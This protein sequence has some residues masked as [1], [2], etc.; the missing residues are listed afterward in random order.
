MLAWIAGLAVVALLAIPALLA[1]VGGQPSGGGEVGGPPAPVEFPHLILN[2][3]DTELVDAY[4]NFDETGERVG[5]HTVYQQTWAIA[6]SDVVDRVGRREILLRIQEEGAVF[7]EFD[8]YSA[9]AMGTETVEVNGRSVTVYL[10]PGEA[11]EEG[12][13]DLGI[14]QWTE[15]PGY[16]V[17]LIPWGLDKDGALSLMDGLTSITES[18]WEELRGPKDGPFVT[19]TIVESETPTTG[20]AENPDNGAAGRAPLPNL[21]GLDFNQAVDVIK[22]FE[23]LTGVRISL[24]SHEQVVNDP[25]LVARVIATDPAPGTV[26]TRT[27]S[28]TV[29]VGK[30]P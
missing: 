28:V 26:I 10:V 4:E 7:D 18:E 8:Y 11:V 27:G 6:D 14:L 30:A 25:N 24:L 20:P 17:I 16:E 9:L 22:E 13:Y 3:P 2:L 23:Q 15:A 5:T 12:S 19:T 21:I 1:G 29:T